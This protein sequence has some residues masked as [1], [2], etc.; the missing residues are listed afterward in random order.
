MRTIYIITTGGTM[1]KVYSERSGAVLNRVSKIERYLKLLRLPD[2][3]V[4]VI[5]LMNKDS[6]DMTQEDR[7]WLGVGVV[8]TA[9]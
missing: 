1:E 7:A 4:R 6:L 5:P 3:D 9:S 2:W 8:F